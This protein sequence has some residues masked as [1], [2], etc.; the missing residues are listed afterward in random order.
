MFRSS[1]I[2]GDTFFS[3]KFTFWVIEIYTGRINYQLSL[4][5]C[6]VHVM[7]RLGMSYVVVLPR[8]GLIT[9]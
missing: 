4:M 7:C 6:I 1:D 8:E 5:P 2:K 3:V 9:I